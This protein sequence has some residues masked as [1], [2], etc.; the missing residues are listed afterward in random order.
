MV[1]GVISIILLALGPWTLH[2]NGQGM[3]GWEARVHARAVWTPENRL[4]LA[5]GADQDSSGGGV[6]M[7]AAG[8][9]G[10]RGMGQSPLGR[11]LCSS[12]PPEWPTPL[13]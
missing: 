3:C 8:G 1:G 9:P 11:G 13:G 5:G 12:A 4:V 7:A 2:C 6:G 10:E